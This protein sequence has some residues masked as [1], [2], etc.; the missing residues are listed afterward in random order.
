MYFP[1]TSV[2][3]ALISFLPVVPRTSRISFEKQPAGQAAFQTSTLLIPEMFQS[4]G[5]EDLKIKREKCLH[6]PSKSLSKF[7]SSILPVAKD[8]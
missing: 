2:E 5:R 3:C 1:R 4:M 7:K 6:S 8:F